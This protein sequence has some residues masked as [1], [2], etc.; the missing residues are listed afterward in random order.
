MSVNRDELFLVLD[1]ASQVFWGEVEKKNL[2]DMATQE[3]SVKDVLGTYH[4]LAPSI[5]YSSKR[6]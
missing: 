4:F 5:M 6:C 2:Q 3:W 1:G